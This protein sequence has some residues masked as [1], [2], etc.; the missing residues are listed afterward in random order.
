M[1][2][3]GEMAELTATHLR[4]QNV[5]RIGVANRSAARAAVL[6]ATVDGVAVPWEGIT[7]ELTTTDIVLTATGAPRWLL[8]RA[9]VAE[10]MRPRRDRPLFMI[11]I[12]LPRD[13]EPS[14]SDVEQVFLYNIDDLQSIVRD[15]LARRQ[16]QVDRAEL[17]V[18]E[19][20]EGF[21]RW[22]RSRGAVPTVVALRKHFERTRQQEL[23][24]LAP[25][26]ASLPPAARTRVEEVTRLL[27]E[28][29]LSSPTQQLK[30]A[31]DEEAVAADADTLSRLFGLDE[32]AAE[33]RRRTLRDRE[34]AGTTTGRP[35][36]PRNR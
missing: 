29:L 20:V 4:A 27:V 11:D 31:P 25:K 2:G 7:A 23:E 26:L 12:G 30:A 17:M 10:A 1:V 33:E 24:R 6:A 35:P 18:R 9:Q 13:V 3:A 22:L 34:P 16:T 21:M 14:A 15:N 5:G 36:A 19:E 8:T 28:K 32:R